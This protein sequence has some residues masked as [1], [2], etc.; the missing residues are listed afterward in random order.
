M[1]QKIKACIIRVR[2]L[3]EVCML[4]LNVSKTLTPS[5]LF[6][7]SFPAHYDGYGRQANMGHEIGSMADA[8]SDSPA[9]NFT[10]LYFASA[11]DYTHKSSETLAAPLAASELFAKLESMYPGIKTKVL[12]SCALTVN[13]QYVDL[14]ESGG[15]EEQTVIGAGD[16]VGIIP[17]VSSG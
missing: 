12:D 5:E 1:I 9:G 13:L 11:S 2:L 16:E 10:V 17:P 14:D 15:S 7:L 3:R 6:R 4:R 8:A